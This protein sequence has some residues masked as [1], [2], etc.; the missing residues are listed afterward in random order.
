[1]A[2]EKVLVIDD[3]LIIRKS[4]EE[5]LR[6]KRYGVTAVATLRSAEKLLR[7]D[8]FDLV[9][10]DVRLPDGDGTEL[11]ELIARQPGHPLTIMMSGVGSVESTVACM[12]NGAFDYL[13]KPFSLS[14]IEVL[15][16]KAEHYQ[17][18]LKL[19]TLHTAQLSA[20]DDFL[21]TSPAIEALHARLDKVAAT[22]AT[23]LVHG[24]PGCGQ[25]LVAHAVCH[26]SVRAAAPY[27]HLN[28]AAAPASHIESKLFGHEKGAFPDAHDRREGL[29]ELADGG[30][31]L[32]EEVGELPLHVQ[33]KVLRFLVDRE[34]E[35]MGGT[36][37]LKVDVRVLATTGRDLCQATS[38]GTFREDLYHR[39]NMLPLAV[40]PLRERQADVIPL[41]TLFLRRL[42]RQ[43]GLITPGFDHAALELFQTYS[44]PGNV[45]ELHNAIERAVLH[46][47]NH[48]PILAVSLGLAADDA[49]AIANAVNSDE[50]SP[51]PLPEMEKAHILRALRYTGDNR[52]KAAALLK[53]SIRTLRNKLKEYRV[54][55]SDN[56]S[57]PPALPH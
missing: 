27:L 52:T 11:L 4:F 41:A 55:G 50:E 23:V 15:V 21:G 34:F 26:A 9:F 48:T 54:Q 37:P 42:A 7:R 53:I 39:L 44:W 38:D 56:R 5:L 13:I 46:T 14:Q 12:H 3:E 8:T 20:T 29:L 32:L 36:K 43:Y 35:R 28:C 25:E 17:Q 45:R 31:L 16:K 1:M 40:P 33:T 30:T 6:G 49:P 2:I 51:S 10:L 57:E 19:N 47:A 24:E 22:D 18:V